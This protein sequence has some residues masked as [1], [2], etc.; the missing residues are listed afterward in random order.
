MKNLKKY[1]TKAE[2]N[3]DTNRD[4]QSSVSYVSN[5]GKCYTDYNIF[6][7]SGTYT[8]SSA[9]TLTFQNASTDASGRRTV[10][11]DTSSG[12]KFSY[13][14]TSASKS[15]YALC[16]KSTSIKKIEDLV[17]PPQCKNVESMFNNATTLTD[18]DL[19]GFK[20]ASVT[21]VQNFVYKAKS[22]TSFTNIN[23]FDLS[24]VENAIQMMAET[25]LPNDQVQSI[26]DR[27]K[28]TNY[29]ALTNMTALCNLCSGTTDLTFDMPTPNVTLMTNMISNNPNL[30]SVTFGKNFDTSNV[31]NFVGL[32]HRSRNLQ[33][34]NGLERFNT[35]NVENM[36]Y[37]FDD[38]SLSS[39][40]I[41][42]FDT[43]KVTSMEGLFANNGNNLSSITMDKCDVSKV[44]NATNMFNGCYS[45]T[46]LKLGKFVNLVSG[47]TMFQGC[48]NL[49]E[50]EVCFGSKIKTEYSEGMFSG[51]TNLK[52]HTDFTTSSWLRNNYQKLGIDTTSVTVVGIVS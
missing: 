7:I 20:G 28:E 18:I 47:K 4:K 24:Q 21:N 16:E 8:G 25:T 44:E 6:K 22:L 48:S 37:V 49:R 11:C 29:G 39:I 12:Y 34:I 5:E 35:S 32:F 50:L 14:D 3:N 2:F 17:V 43:S 33:Q 27:F 51:C 23:C 26:L 31:T 15:L 1:T 30:T 52:I 38:T 19:K 10:T 40:D 42:H 36:G 13:T 41:N 45:I 46:K 9:P